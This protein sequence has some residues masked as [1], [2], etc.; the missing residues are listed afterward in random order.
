MGQG[1]KVRNENHLWEMGWVREQGEPTWPKPT[2]E[3]GEWHRREERPDH[4]WKTSNQPLSHCLQS[5]ST[6]C[7]RSKLGINQST[8][9]N[10]KRIQETYTGKEQRMDVLEGKEEI[11]GGR[12]SSLFVYCRYLFPTSHFSC[13][14]FADLWRGK[15]QL[16]KRSQ[17]TNK[18]EQQT[19]CSQ[20][21]I[22]YS[23]LLHLFCT[24][25]R[26]LRTPNT[27]FQFSPPGPTHQ[28]I[29]IKK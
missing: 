24:K 19:L 18:T 11:S 14:S 7:D 9:E 4:G 2:Q 27:E 25:I 10:K 16:G 15:A 26:L 29:K 13:S 20:R 22:V 5:E 8:T 17:A 23:C 3:A 28:S 1:G 21:H 6:D 12:A